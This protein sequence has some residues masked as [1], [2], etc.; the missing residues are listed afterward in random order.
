MIQITMWW[1]QHHAIKHKNSLLS[2]CRFPA[3]SNDCKIAWKM[4]QYQEPYKWLQ[5]DCVVNPHDNKCN[6]YGQWLI[7]EHNAMSNNNMMW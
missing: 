1:L 6:K 7:D 2:I 4:E 3:L 5:N